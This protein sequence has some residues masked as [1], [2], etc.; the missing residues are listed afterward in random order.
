MPTTDIP[1]PSDDAGQPSE[2]LAPKFCSP[3]NGAFC[4]AY[5]KIYL[6][7]VAMDTSTPDWQM[8]A[9]D[10]GISIEEAHCIAADLMVAIQKASRIATGRANAEVRRGDEDPQ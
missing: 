3:K 10:H 5:G 9:V 7:V 4:N 1:T 2:G 8:R 6:R